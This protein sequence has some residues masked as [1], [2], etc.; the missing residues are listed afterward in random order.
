[1]KT[2][3]YLFFAI[4]LSSCTVFEDDEIK[5]PIPVDSISVN[6]IS[7][8]FVD[9]IASVFCGSMCWKNTYFEERISGNDVFIKTL[10]VLD[11]SSVCPAVCVDYQTPIN[12]SLLSAGSYTFHFW[13][14]DT[15]SIDTSLIIN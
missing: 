1:M 9:F 5:R 14:S 2:I 4:I 12:I 6:N 10:A 7:N 8:L 13:K 3:A 11:G 15:S